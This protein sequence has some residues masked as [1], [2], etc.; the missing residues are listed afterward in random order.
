MALA[1][2]IALP[3]SPSS[4]FSFQ[5]L[6]SISLL[7]HLIFYLHPRRPKFPDAGVVL[8]YQNK[9]GQGQDC[10]NDHQSLR[11]AFPVIGQ[12]YVRNLR[13]IVPD[14]NAAGIILHEF[15][16]C[17][18]GDAQAALSRG[19]AGWQNYGNRPLIPEGKYELLALHR[20]GVDQLSG[21]IPL[22]GQAVDML[23]PPESIAT[24]EGDVLAVFIE[25]RHVLRLV[26][27]SEIQMAGTDRQSNH[28][29]PLAQMVGGAVKLGAGRADAE[30]PDGA[31]G[32]QGYESPLACYAEMIVH[33]LTAAM[34]FQ[35]Y[36]LRARLRL[37]LYA[38]R[39]FAA[40]REIYGSRKAAKDAKKTTIDRMHQQ[41][42]SSQK[43][44]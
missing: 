32:C 33:R 28:R 43:E 39:V 27:E 9:A 26:G 38:F 16:R 12:V 6:F 4:S 42:L 20:H 40:W 37:N 3:P 29:L 1:L 15:I 7:L 34:H 13:G 5:S 36:Q 10:E 21:D 30:N 31:Y 22:P 19:I 44:R 23:T 14:E 41:N 35:P 24:V 11:S 2:L 17:G 8:A 25:E 18:P